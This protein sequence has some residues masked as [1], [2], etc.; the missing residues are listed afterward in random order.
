MLYKLSVPTVHGTHS[1]NEN[2]SAMEV[3]VSRVCVAM[4]VTVSRVCVAMELTASHMCVA[5]ELTA[6]HAG[7]LPWSLLHRTLACFHVNYCIARVCC[8]G[9]YCIARLVWHDVIG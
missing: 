6:S 4:E 9:A 7:V 1:Y 2:R 5:M 3:T 8:H